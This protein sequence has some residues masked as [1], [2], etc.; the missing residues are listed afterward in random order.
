MIDKF[1]FLSNNPYPIVL[2]EF[3]EEAYGFFDIFSTIL[4]VSLREKYMNTYSI[5]FE[6]INSIQKKKVNCIEKL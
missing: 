3:R 1:Y 5:V 4:T 2:L 6:T